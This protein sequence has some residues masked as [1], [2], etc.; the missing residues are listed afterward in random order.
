M[1]VG[2]LKSFGCHQQPSLCF[3]SHSNLLGNG[4]HKGTQF[5]GNGHHDLVGMFAF[6]HQVAI[7]FAEPDLGFPAD[8][9]DRCGELFQAQLAGDD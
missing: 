3:G 7:P 6:G 9:L 4:P 2:I 5:P 1:H 8:R